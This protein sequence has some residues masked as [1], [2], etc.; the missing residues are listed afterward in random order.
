MKK[1]Y[2]KKQLARMIIEA[3]ENI[4]IPLETLVNDLDSIYKIRKIAVKIIN[5]NEYD[6]RLLNNLFIISNN[7]FGNNVDRLYEI[8]M[9]PQEIEVIKKL[10]ELNDTKF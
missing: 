2:S 7:A 10:S 1:V 5:E 4:F 9:T 8:I 3:N 6:H